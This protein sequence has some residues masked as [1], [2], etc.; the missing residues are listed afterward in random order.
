MAKYEYKW[1]YM[2]ESRTGCTLFLQASSRYG[3]ASMEGPGEIR[4]ERCSDK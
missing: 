1:R 2:Y 4:P 3:T